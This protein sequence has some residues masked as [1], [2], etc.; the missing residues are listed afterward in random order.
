MLGAGQPQ[1][2][3][4]HRC[5]KCEA[6]ETGQQEAGSR[7]QAMGCTTAAAGQVCCPMGCTH[8]VMLVHKQQLMVAEQASSRCFS[9]PC[10]S[11][12]QCQSCPFTAG[13][14]HLMP[15]VECSI[16]YPHLRCPSSGLLLTCCAG[17]TLAA[18]GT[19]GGTA[20]AA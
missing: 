16:R 5:P 19:A 12:R 18:A 20:A 2:K 6:H 13:Q 11:P 4:Q 8:A 7:Q 1:V 3:T 14:N 17:A 15:P 10:R 9:T